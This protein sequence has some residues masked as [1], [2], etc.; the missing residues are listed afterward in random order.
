MHKNSSNLNE[1]Q[2]D[3]PLYESDDLPTLVDDDGDF[4][5]AGLTE[6]REMGATNLSTIFLLKRVGFEASLLLLPQIY[7]LIVMIVER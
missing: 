5:I 7:C 4:D 6:I 3:C 2:R 1:V